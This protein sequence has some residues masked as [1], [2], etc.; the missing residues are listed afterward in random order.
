MTIVLL[1]IRMHF[2]PRYVTLILTARLR[3]ATWASGLLWCFCGRWFGGFGGLVDGARA[4]V[5]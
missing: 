2:I 4:G 1:T 3:I 5:R